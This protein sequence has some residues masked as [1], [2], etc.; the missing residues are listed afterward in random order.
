[1]F[2][3]HTS[4][5]HR[6]WCLHIAFCCSCTVVFSIL[7]NLSSF[8]NDSL[9]YILVRHG[10]QGSTGFRNPRASCSILSVARALLKVQGIL[11]PV[12]PEASNWFRVQNHQFHWTIQKTYIAIKHSLHEK[13]LSCIQI[14]RFN[15]TYFAMRCGVAHLSLYS[16]TQKAYHT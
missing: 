7:N 14:W 6:H 11:N 15:K 5:L 2:E 1:M 4:Q 12:D 3:S 10:F 16:M 13:M 8:Y 9:F